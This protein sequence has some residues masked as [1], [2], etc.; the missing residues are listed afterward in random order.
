MKKI[1]GLDKTILEVRDRLK[2]NVD[3]Y[4]CFDGRF[5]LFLSVLS[6]INSLRD[7]SVRSTRT[8]YHEIE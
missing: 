7:I 1:L 5:F 8:N 4:E 3:F 2:V 6:L